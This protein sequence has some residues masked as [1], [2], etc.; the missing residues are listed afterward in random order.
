MAMTANDST[1]RLDP[2]ASNGACH[3]CQVAGETSRGEP[4]RHDRD[5]VTYD[6]TPTRVSGRYSEHALQSVEEREMA[7]GGM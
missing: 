2:A 3:C 4:D 1:F 6:L 5:L 7:L